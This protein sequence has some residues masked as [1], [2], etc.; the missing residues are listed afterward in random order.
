MLRPRRALR[1][2]KSPLRTVPSSP[3]YV[4]LRSS[5]FL[6]EL[7][8]D[9]LEDIL[10]ET[11]VLRRALR[12]SLRVRLPRMRRASLRRRTFRSAEDTESTVRTTRRTLKLWRPSP[13]RR[14]PLRPSPL[15]RSLLRPTKCY[16]NLKCTVC[17]LACTC[18]LI[19]LSVALFVFCL[20]TTK[21]R[22][23]VKEG[24]ELV[25]C[26]SIVILFAIEIENVLHEADLLLLKF[27]D[28]DFDGVVHVQLVDG[29][30]SSLPDA[31]NTINGLLFHK[32]IPPG[33]TNKHHTG[34]VQA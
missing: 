28:L 10:E 29:H 13:L 24:A 18:I 21:K 11:T 4:S 5:P 9:S 8:A 6:R 16:C 27:F 32:G 15:R 1:P 33:V 31:M 12:P 26:E 17:S 22:S 19:N 20:N 23:R 30:W 2:E 7:F 25:D 14:S 3:R 34:S